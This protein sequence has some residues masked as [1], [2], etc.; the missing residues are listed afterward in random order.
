MKNAQATKKKKRNIFLRIALLIFA[1]YI[2]VTLIQLQLQINDTQAKINDKLI[3][4]TEL[5]EQIEEKKNKLENS[6][7]YLEEQAR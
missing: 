2:V 6:E 1:V 5:S 4:K 3:E 7:R